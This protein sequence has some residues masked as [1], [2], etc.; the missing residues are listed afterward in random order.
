ML[1]LPFEEVD[2]VGSYGEPPEALFYKKL[3]EKQFDAFL[4][5]PYLE[6][7][8]IHESVKADI[9][10]SEIKDA[11]REHDIDLIIMGS[12]GSSGIREMFIGS[13]AEKVVRNS[14]VPVLVIKNNHDDF[15][16]NDFVFA[17]DF[18]NDN[19]ETLQ[20]SSKFCQIF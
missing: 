13:N 7:L 3:A 4:D 8:T 12:H 11:C 19:K 20:A 9:S 2:V 18:K 5:K 10:F 1:Q 15:E 6:D 16:I 14:D 17:S